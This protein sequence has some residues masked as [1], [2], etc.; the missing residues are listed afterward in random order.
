MQSSIEE[1]LNYAADIILTGDINIDF[2][3][4]TNSK[5]RAFLTLF[6]LT[7]V[8]DEPTRI[9]P[10]VATLTDPVLVSDSCRVLDSGTINVDGFISD[11]KATYVSIRINVFQHLTTEKY[12]TINMPITQLLTIKYEYKNLTG[13]VLL[14]SHHLLM[15]LVNSFIVSLWIFL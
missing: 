6:N 7:N 1:A 14:M 13:R 8:I 15:K 10:N 3:Q 11:H 12:G 2:L 9:T 4:L 5:L